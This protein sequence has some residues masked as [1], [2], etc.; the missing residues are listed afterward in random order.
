VLT[1]D[2]IARL[3]A[4]E[5]AGLFRYLARL[6]GDGDRA[7]DAAQEAFVR[8]VERPPMIPDGPAAAGAVRAWLYTVATNVVREGGRTH[9]RRA[10]LLAHG[11][12][13]APMADPPRDAH[14]TVEADEER[15]RVRAAL[16]GL[17]AKER[18]AL[19]MREEG[20]AHREIAA[21]VG[22]TTGSVGTLLARALDK[23]AA[24][25]PLD[26]AAP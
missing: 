12:A 9:A 24:A 15:R 20:F 7:A 19:L 14:A 26:E 22:A 1:S 25:L 13:R 17:S 10:W 16:D 18:T 11:A 5:H 2:A 21:A 8:L 6:T 23:L 4:T 3:F